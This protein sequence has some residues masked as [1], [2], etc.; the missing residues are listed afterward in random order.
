MDKITGVEPAQSAAVPHADYPKWIVPHGSHVDEQ[1]RALA[2]TEFHK[3]RDGVTTVLV[4]SKN[5]EEI[6]LAP[7]DGS[8]TG[9]QVGG[10]NLEKMAADI[11]NSGEQKKEQNDG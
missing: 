4:K 1:G 2:F 3:G 9:Q 8:E 5:E 6:A 10:L 11:F 7:K